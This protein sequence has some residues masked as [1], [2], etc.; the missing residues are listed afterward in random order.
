LYLQPFFVPAP[1]WYVRDFGRVHEGAPSVAWASTVR[2]DRR[3]PPLRTGFPWRTID[4]LR[5]NGIVISVLATP[6]YFKDQGPWP[7]GSWATPDLSTA[8]VRGPE[9]EEPV[10]PISVYEISGPY[11]VTRVYF[12]SR[13][14]TE[15]AVERAQRELSR[16]QLPPA[17]PEPS[18]STRS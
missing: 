18:G 5:L 15:R 12:G 6:W 13:F 9:A 7:E 14:P 3:D 11:A 17:C 8:E 1:G 10:R 16:L 4:Q 2:F